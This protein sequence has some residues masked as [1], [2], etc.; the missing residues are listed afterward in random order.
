MV[1]SY[2]WDNYI[3]ED[4]QGFKYM[5]FNQ[6]KGSYLFNAPEV[7]KCDNSKS[8]KKNVQKKDRYYNELSDMWSIGIIAY[9]LCTGEHPFE[10]KAYHDKTGKN[11]KNMEDEAIKKIRDF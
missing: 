8:K 5:K 10:E 1:Y 11:K 4:N 6:V 9:I 3:H 2:H 7:L